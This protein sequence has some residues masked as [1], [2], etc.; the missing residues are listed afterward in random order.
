[1]DNVDALKDKTMNTFYGDLVSGY[2]C[3]F[4]LKLDCILLVKKCLGT[5]HP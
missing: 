4:K 2:K 1:M 5:I 3:Q